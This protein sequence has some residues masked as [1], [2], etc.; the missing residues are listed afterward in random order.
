LLLQFPF[1]AQYAGDLPG[2]PAVMDV[3]DVFFVSRLRE[4]A[5]QHA[6]LPRLKRLVSW[7]AWTRYE[8]RWYRQCQSVMA[9]TD[10][11]RA[12]LNAL[13]PEVPA[14]TVPAAMSFG[15]PCAP[16][17]ASVHRVGF[18]GN[19]GHPPNLD[20]LS[21]LSR[22]IAPR[23]ARLHPGVE[24]VVAGR[25]VSEAVRAGLH[26]CVRLE[27][28][29]EDYHR[30]LGS[31]TL[32]LAPLRFGG[33]VKIKVLDALGCGRPVVTTAIGAEGI[34]L[35]LDEGLQV[36][37]SADELAA[38]AAAI[39]ADPS[40]ALAAAARGA[41]HVARLYSADAAVA[42]FEAGVTPLLQTRSADEGLALAS[43]LGTRSSAAAS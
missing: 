16:H 31:C 26:P 29:V 13:V 34:D 28:F 11:D 9:L 33:G 38:L 1:M 6:A 35:G 8:L 5:A 42:L 39:L 41:A 27:G 10:P 43:G 22:E 15:V 40:S 12:A 7:L 19:F 4:Y 2:V 20:A 3:Q 18:G 36:A 17:L 14:F 23:L 25:G 32:F 37:H 21:W 30:F 24:I